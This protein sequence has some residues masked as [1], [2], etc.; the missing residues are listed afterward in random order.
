MLAIYQLKKGKPFFLAQRSEGGLSIY[1]VS[2][3]KYLFCA[4]FCAEC[5]E[6][7]DQ[8]DIVAA[9]QK[10]RLQ[11]VLGRGLGWRASRMPPLIG[12]THFLLGS[13]GTCRF[14]LRTV[15]D[16]YCHQEFLPSGIIAAGRSGLLLT[17]VQRVRSFFYLY[18]FK[19]VKLSNKQ[20][21]PFS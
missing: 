9:L 14:Q 10:L 4:S 11:A 15:K 18:N 6:H 3:A 8:Q 16:S 19:P 12:S 2:F 1:S 13:S 21:S 5:R 7:N 20:C 17:R